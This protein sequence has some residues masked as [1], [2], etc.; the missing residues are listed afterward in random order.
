MGWHVP[1][2][3]EWTVLSTFLG[4]PNSGEKMKMSPLFGPTLISYV[5]E[6]GY[7]DQNWVSCS[8]CEVA[9][10]EYKK[11]CPS[12]K[13]MGGKSVQGKYIPK[14]KRKVEEKGKEIGGWNGTNSSGFSGLPGGCR[15]SNGYFH[16]VGYDGFWWSASEGD[17]TTAWRKTLYYKISDLMGSNYYSKSIGYSVRCV[18]D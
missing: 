5:D 7:Y 8:N 2:D 17:E 12:C 3:Q 10:P 9:S 14:T 6:G 1:T 18:K 16:Q 13:G 4:G 15:I 11:I